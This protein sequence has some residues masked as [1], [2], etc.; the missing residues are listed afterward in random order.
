[1]KSYLFVPFATTG[2]ADEVFVRVI[3]LRDDPSG[4]R[5]GII[6]QKDLRTLDPILASRVEEGTS[7]DTKKSEKLVTLPFGSVIFTV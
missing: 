2:E 4:Q 7:G 6:V 1:M 3:G 5:A